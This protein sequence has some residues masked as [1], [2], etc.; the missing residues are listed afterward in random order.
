MPKYKSKTKV[1]RGQA[2]QNYCGKSHSENLGKDPSTDS[3]ALR[4]STTIVE[5]HVPFGMAV[6]EDTSSPD[7]THQQD[8]ILPDL[9][10]KKNQPVTEKRNLSSSRIVYIKSFFFKCKKSTII[11]HITVEYKV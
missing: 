2:L 11:A 8:A 3:N 9:T 6:D 10:I 7:I 5:T 1:K 4:S